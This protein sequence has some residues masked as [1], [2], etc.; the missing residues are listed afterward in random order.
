MPTAIPMS[1]TTSEA[2]CPVGNQWPGMASSE[3]AVITEVP[4]SSSGMPAAIS[5]PNTSTSRISVTGSE[6]DLGLAE[7]GVDQLGDGPVAAGVTGLLDQQVRVAGLH[8]GHRVQVAGHGLVHVVGVPRDRERDQGA[9]PVGGDQ[10]LAVRAERR[11][12]VVRGPRPGA[13]GRGHLPGGLPQLRVGRERPARAPRL[14]QHV[15]GG[16]GRSR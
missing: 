11:P 13:Q 12:D 15:L 7:V 4:A 6:V 10:R 2:F 8:R 16:R 3:I 1:S 9:A 5:A 14:D